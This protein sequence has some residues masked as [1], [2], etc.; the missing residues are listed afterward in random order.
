MVAEIFFAASM[1]AEFRRAKYR[2]YSRVARFDGK[3]RLAR[4]HQMA[5]EQARPDKPSAGSRNGK[6]KRALHANQLQVTLSYHSHY[7][8][9]Y[10]MKGEF[11][12]H[13]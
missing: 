7:H 4:R 11:L 1:A 3:H 10:R 6:P 5:A 9:A 2:H 12:K 13:W 8:Y